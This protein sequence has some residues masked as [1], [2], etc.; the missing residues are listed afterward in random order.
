M[1]S[2]IGIIKGSDKVTDLSWDPF[3]SSYLLS[4]WENSTISLWD[5]EN[6]QEIHFFNKQTV[7][8]K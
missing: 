7:G 8:F 4:S 2:N 5:T 3:S 1:T 6:Y